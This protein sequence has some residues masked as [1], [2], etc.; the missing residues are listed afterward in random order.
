M[1]NLRNLQSFVDH[2]VFQETGREGVDW[3]AV[4][5][6]GEGQ[7]NGCCESCNKLLYSNTSGARG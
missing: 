6:A 7:V 4:T 5:Q 3:I 1:L 2:K